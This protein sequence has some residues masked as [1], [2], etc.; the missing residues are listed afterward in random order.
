MTITIF[1]IERPLIFTM[2]PGTTDIERYFKEHCDRDKKE[3]IQI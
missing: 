2:S 3:I 1:F